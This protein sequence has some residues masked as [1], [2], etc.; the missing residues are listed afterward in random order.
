MGLHEAGIS[1][2]GL[3]SK[4]L[5]EMPVLRND[6]S[7]VREALHLALMPSSKSIEGSGTKGYGPLS[8]NSQSR[9]NWSCG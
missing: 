1:S 2:V 8:L 6:F 7:R 5:G 9:P 3:L 4:R